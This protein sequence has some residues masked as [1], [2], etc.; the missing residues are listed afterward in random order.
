[1]PLFLAALFVLAAIIDNSK[2]AA[3]VI[4]V[5]G[6][7]F[8]L[9]VI[10]NLV[11]MIWPWPRRSVWRDSDAQPCWAYL[12][13]ARNEA[14]SWM[15]RRWGS[16]G[17]V[18]VSGWIGLFIAL[19]S[20]TAGALFFAETLFPKSLVLSAVLSWFMDGELVVVAC[21][22]ALSLKRGVFGSREP[23]AKVI[24]E[25][26]NGEMVLLSEWREFCGL[27][28][29]PFSL[30]RYLRLVIPVTGWVYHHFFFDGDMAALTAVMAVAMVYFAY[31]MV[32][33]SFDLLAA[34]NGVEV[35]P[36][37]SPYLARLVWESQ[38]LVQKHK[39]MWARFLSSV[40]L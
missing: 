5:V 33:V 39:P 3:I 30:W 27:V 29:M 4:G 32:D 11:G 13:S 40:G 2:K 21:L 38:F 1:M 10:G 20:A 6:L 23:P 12:I 26:L 31:I 17:W 25:R 15:L 36:C 28:P 37:R 9:S 34:V 35:C 8:L 7:I 16:A 24:R 18:R 14:E 19:L 22:F